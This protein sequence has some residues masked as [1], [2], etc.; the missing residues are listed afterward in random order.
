ML[1][2]E[3]ALREMMNNGTDK[4]R[5][6]HVVSR[7]GNGLN[8]PETNSLPHRWALAQRIPSQGDG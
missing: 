5:Y 3:S 1:L 2:R 8:L 6:E 4:T 7:G